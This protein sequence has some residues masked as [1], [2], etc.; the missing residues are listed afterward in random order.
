MSKFV[1]VTVEKD[2]K[3]EEIFVDPAYGPEEHK[4]N[5][6]K[7]QKIKNKQKTEN[8]KGIKNDQ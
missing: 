3:E 6:N 5:Q 4:N 8:L 7:T 2:F 1:K